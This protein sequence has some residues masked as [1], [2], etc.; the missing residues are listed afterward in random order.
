MSPWSYRI[1]WS[2]SPTLSDSYQPTVKVGTYHQTGLCK[3]YS[4]PEF[5][6]LIIW[7]KK[8]VI[9]KTK[10]NFTNHQG[11]MIQTST[12]VQNQPILRAET[13]PNTISDTHGITTQKLKLCVSLTLLPRVFL[14]LS[15]WQVRRDIYTGVINFSSPIFFWCFFGVNLDDIFHPPPCFFSE[16]IQGICEGIPDP[17]KRR[18]PF[19][20]VVTWVTYRWTAL[21]ENIGWSNWIMP[22]PKT[23]LSE[24]WQ[25]FK[26][27]PNTCW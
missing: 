22:P 3:N 24:N 1:L 18:S 9:Q 23:F 16:K 14:Y 27:S 10:E 4:P 19:K 15:W 21:F 26:S 5:E 8:H 12:S 2:R 25:C 20:E 7:R 6:M 17:P 11:Y 13:S